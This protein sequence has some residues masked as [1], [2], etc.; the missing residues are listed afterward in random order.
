M[1]RFEGDG[2]PPY[3][4]LG[5]ICIPFANLKPHALPRG[6]KEY[7]V[8]GFPAT[9]TKAHVKN[10]TVEIEPYGNRTQ[11]IDDALYGG[12]GFNP[13]TSIALDFDVKSVR[14]PNGQ[15]Q[16]APEPQGMS[17]SPVWELIDYAGPNDPTRSC[18]VG[19]LIEHRRKNKLLVATDIAV[20]MQLINAYG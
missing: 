12:L 19:I 20:A 8:T 13:K 11:S 1:L 18:V 15:L 6:T 5:T 10:Q 3:P 14:R 17:G 2:Q 9:R 16:E 7:F 4:D